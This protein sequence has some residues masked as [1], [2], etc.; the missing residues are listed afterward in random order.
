MPGTCSP[1]RNTPIRG[2]LRTRCCRTLPARV[3]T[4]PLH[5]RSVNVRGIHPH[6]A[7]QRPPRSRFRHRRDRPRCS[8]PSSSIWDAASMAASTS[9]GTRRPTR[10]ASGA[11]CWRWYGAGAD[12]HALSGRQFRLRLQLGGRG[13]PGEQ[14]PTRL[15]LAW[16]S[17]ET[18]TFGTNEFIDWCRTAGVEPMFAVNLGTRGAMPRAISSNTAII[19]AARHSS[20]LRRAHG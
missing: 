6:A 15:D 9:R 1:T 18:N 7:S 12:H 4:H 20:D 11:T 17:T 14:R 19:P 10:M 16:L 5:P 3:S 8:A 2:N 13:R